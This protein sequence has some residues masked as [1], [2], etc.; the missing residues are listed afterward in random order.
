MTGELIFSSRWWA[1]WSNPLIAI[2]EE[3]RVSLPLTKEQLDNIDYFN[4]LQLRSTLNMPELP[5]DRLILRPELRSIAI[6]TNSVLEEHLQ[7]FALFSLDASILHARPQ[8]W[9][10]SFGVNSPEVIREIIVLKNDLPEA[11][12]QWQESAARHMANTLKKQLF[13]HD[14][15]RLGFAVYLRSYFPKIYQRWQLTQTKEIIDWSNDLEPIPQELW[16]VIDHW[17]EAAFCALHS[18]VYSHHE[19]LELNFDPDGTS[20]NSIEEI[21]FLHKEDHA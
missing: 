20:D 8:D 2:H 6:A 12:I 9:E 16:D 3:H 11:L 7:R 21:D 17:S 19:V 1:W 4:L 10:S 13:L 5:D 14:R 15:I 18:E